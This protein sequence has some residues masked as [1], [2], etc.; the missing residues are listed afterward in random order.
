LSGNNNSGTLT[1]STLPQYITSSNTLFFNGSTSYV[2]VPSLNY[3]SGSSYTFNTWVLNNWALTGQGVT[4]WPMI[5]RDGNSSGNRLFIGIKIGTGTNLGFN[6]Y[7]SNAGAFETTNI[8][9]PTSNI[10]YNVVTTHTAGTASIYSNAILISQTT[11][12]ITF[13]GTNNAG[14]MIANGSAGGNS[15]WSGSISIVQAYNRALS[16]SEILQN[17]NAQKSRFGLK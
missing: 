15:F 10:W 9:P 8:T 12:S 7:M 3:T 14:I 5:I 6:V 1:G 16:A 11:S 13:A 2:S 4:P 17:Y